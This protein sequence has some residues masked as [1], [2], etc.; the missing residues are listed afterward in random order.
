[1]VKPF[2]LPRNFTWP[3]FRS[4]AVIAQV[5]N[6]T[7]EKQKKRV[8]FKKNRNISRGEGD[9]IRL[10]GQIQSAGNTRDVMLANKA[11]SIALGSVVGLRLLAAA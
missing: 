11:L 4:H 10:D 6:L 3:H 1:M 8:G 2:F 7:L 5:F 9:A